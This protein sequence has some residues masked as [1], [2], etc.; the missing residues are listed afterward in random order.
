ML[1][2]KIKEEV[3][4]KAIVPLDERRFLVLARTGNSKLDIVGGRR[5][6]LASGKIEKPEDTIR[7]ELAE[8]T[9]QKLVVP[10]EILHTYRQDIYPKGIDGGHHVD[11]HTYLAAAEGEARLINLEEHYA[12]MGL[13]LSQA[14][15]ERYR[16][17]FDDSTLEMLEKRYNFI[18]THLGEFIVAKSQIIIP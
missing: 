17:Q 16:T 14:V 11:R 7:R 3:G 4:Y 5:K 2:G 9:G 12:V 15:N 10:P 1:T 6:I 13:T 8:E 18:M